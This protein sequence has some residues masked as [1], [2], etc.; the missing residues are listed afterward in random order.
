MHAVLDRTFD[1]CI[2]ATQ[3][4]S[5]LWC[6][7]LRYCT[8]CLYGLDVDRTLNY[9]LTDWLTV[10]AVTKTA[11]RQQHNRTVITRVHS[12]YNYTN[13]SNTYRYSDVQRTTLISWTRHVTRRACHTLGLTHADIVHCYSDIQRTMTTTTSA[14]PER[15]MQQ[16]QK[17]TAAKFVM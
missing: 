6:V 5:T 12:L 1:V 10:V 4:S 15:Q 11:G 17:S 8:A 9:W 13:K 2:S 3:F 7:L 14:V 16:S